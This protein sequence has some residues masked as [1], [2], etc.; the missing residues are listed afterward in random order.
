MSYILEALKRAEAERDRGAVPTLHSQPQVSRAAA[1]GARAVS[2]MVAALSALLVIALVV[3]ATLWWRGRAPAD[4]APISV[5]PAP[6][7]PPVA[8]APPVVVAPPVV[9]AAPA[10]APAPRPKPAPVPPPPAP[11]A[12]PTPAAPAPAPMAVPAAKPSPA[13][14]DQAP[15]RIYAMAELPPD[16]RQQLPKISINGASYSEQ[17]AY[18]MLI[19]NGQVFHEKDEIT[20]GLVLESIGPKSA[21]L[22]FNGYRFSQGF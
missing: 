13:P 3:I 1:P 5:A 22:R 17:A 2:P 8:A 6:A 16:V 7:A 11:T 15:S 19:V 18:R 21:V 9:A 20:G 4:P 14:V 10:P 12:A